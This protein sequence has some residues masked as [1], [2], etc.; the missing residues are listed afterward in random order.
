MSRRW[1][2]NAVSTIARTRPSP[3]AR[4]ARRSTPAPWTRPAWRTTSSC[5][6]RWPAPPTAWPTAWRRRPTARSRASLRAGA[7]TAS[8]RGA[9]PPALRYRRRMAAAADIAHYAALDARLVQA[10][11]GIRLLGLAS[12]PATV[13]AQF[14]AGWR[15]GRTALP[16]VQYPALDFSQARRALAA[17][18]SE[19][20]ADHPLGV[21]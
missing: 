18:A 3:A 8:P 5:A 20:D 9:E 6:T 15:S 11:R 16:Q 17:I 19:A 13:Q 21:Y 2:R 7:R 4:C 10:V 14:L 12:W 1:P